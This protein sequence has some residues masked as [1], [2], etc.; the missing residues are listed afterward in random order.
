MKA[1]TKDKK[2]YN[3]FN[4]GIYKASLR[5][6]PQYIHPYIWIGITDFEF[7]KELCSDRIL[8]VVSEHFNIKIKELLGRKRFK[9]ILIPRYVAWHIMYFYSELNTMV[10][11]SKRFRR[12]HST[13]V[14]GLKQIRYLMS[15]DDYYFNKYTEITII[16]GI[17]KIN[18]RQIIKNLCK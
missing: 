13:I 17:F 12:D 11:I 15:Y 14:N 1:Y 16:L 4:R 6:K 8:E 9:Q 18:Q 3:Y 10:S 7:N 5:A 2:Q